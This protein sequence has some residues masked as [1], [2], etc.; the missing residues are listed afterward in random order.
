LLR[1]LARTAQVL[2]RFGPK[3]PGLVEE[4]L[5]RP[6]PPPEPPAR[7]PWRAALWFAAGAAVA[8]AGVALGTLV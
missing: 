4:R 7:R 2:M 1:D 3:L 8:L 5:L 6:A